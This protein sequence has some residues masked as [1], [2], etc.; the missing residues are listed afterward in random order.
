M[1]KFILSLLLSAFVFVSVHDYIIESIDH[2]TQSEL[3]LYESGQIDA[4]CDVTKTHE[5]LHESLIAADIIFTSL[6]LSCVSKNAIDT[7]IQLFP[8]TSPQ[9]IFNPPIA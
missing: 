2:D 5:I 9:S 3:Y 1:K 8:T 4:V 6:C 7:Y